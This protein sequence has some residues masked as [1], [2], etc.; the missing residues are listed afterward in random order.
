MHLH[1]CTFI[2]AP[3]LHKQRK[4]WTHLKCGSALL[5][6]CTTKFCVVSSLS[7]F[8]GLD[9]NWAF[10]AGL[11]LGV[12]L[13][14][15]DISGLF[16]E[17]IGGFVTSDECPDV[18]NETHLTGSVSQTCWAYLEQSG[19]RPWSREGGEPLALWTPL[20]DGIRECSHAAFGGGC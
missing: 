15:L 12:W 11:A 19:R 2:L 6:C 13:P 14:N 5:V 7:C 4:R 16:M 20:R 18:A 10:V 3:S 8:G 17:V 9:G 1:L